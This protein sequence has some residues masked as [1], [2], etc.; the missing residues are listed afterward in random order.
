MLR[1]FK[2]LNILLVILLLTGCSAEYSITINSIEDINESLNIIEKDKSKFDVKNEQ[3]YNSTLRQY[4]DT[5][6]KWP[7]PVFIDQVENPIEPTKIEGI[8]YYNKK[9][10]S[11][12]SKLE[13][14]YNYNFNNNNYKESNILNTCYEYDYEVINNVFT[15][16]TTS[17]FKCFE[18]YP[19]L[20]NIDFI[21]NTTCNVISSDA[22]SKT[23]NKFT[24]NIKSRDKKI[25]F[26]LDC[27]KKKNI[28]IP[29]SFVLPFYFALIGIGI[30]ILKISYKI[31]NKF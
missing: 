6:M 29:F 15:F 19:L 12:S 4:L 25:N 1:L 26:S 22:D 30:I 31:S 20:E 23:D 16:K 27:S 13:I 9:N 8:V 3:L 24:W 2:R 14:N 7:T 18:K 28:K 21:L 10:I 17:D 5:N 11:N